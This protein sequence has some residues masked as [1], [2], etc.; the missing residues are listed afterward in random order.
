MNNFLSHK[1]IK[2]SCLTYLIFTITSYCAFSQL[3]SAGQNPPSV[4]FKQINTDQFQIIYPTLLEIEAQ[5]MANVLTHIID[6]VSN[7]LGQKPKPISI[8]LQT[9]GVVSNGFVQMAPRRSEFYTIPGQEFDAQDWLNS[10]AVHE[11]R[12]VVQFD[13]LGPNLNAPLFEELKLAIFGINLP[14]WFF[15]G[16]A[17]GIETALT[18]AGRGRQPNFELVLRTNELE[19]NKFSYSKNYFGSFKNYTPGYYP[20]GYFMTTKIRRDFGPDIL[21]QIL[22]RIKRLPIRPYN[23]S[24]SLKKYGGVT[25]PQLYKNTMQELDSLW[26]TNRE[27]IE[28]K[29]YA[30]LQEEDTKLPTSYILPYLM[31]DGNVIC[32]KGSKAQ[33]PAIIKI[34]D[35]KEEHL[36]NIGPQIEPNLHY[37][38]NKVVW[39]EYRADP[40]FSQRSFNVICI[41]D[42]ETS[43]YRQL[44]TKTRLFSPALSADGKKIIAVKV[45][46]ENIFNL[47]EIDAE[48]GDEIK[49]YP[50]PKNFTLQTPQFNQSGEQIVVTAVNADGKTLLLYRDSQMIQ[51]LP[52]ERQIISRPTFYQNQVIYKAHYNG[53]DNIYSVDLSSKKI[54]QLTQA[55]FGVYQPSVNKNGILTFSDYQVQGYNIAS[56]DL[57]AAN[58]FKP[59]DNGNA[60]VNYFEPL[61]QQENKSDVFESTPAIVYESTPYKD[62]DH[63]FYFHSLRPIIE[64]NPFLDDNDYGFDLASNNKLNTL[65]SAFGYRYNNALGR[66]GYKA[67][68]SYQKYYPQLSLNYENR[69]RLSFTRIIN[70][71]QDTSIV[72]FQWRENLTTLNIRVPYFKNWLNKNFSSSFNIETSYTNRYQATL[73]PN[74]FANKIA[75]PLTYQLFAGLNWATSQRDLAPKWGQNF[76]LSYEHLPFDTNLNGENLVFRSQ[77]Y[78][79]GFARNHSFQASYNFQTN[80]G[81]YNFGNDIPRASGFANLAPILNLSNT[82][83]LDYRFPIFYPDWEVGALAYVKRLKGGFFV[84]YENIGNGKGLRSYGAELRADLNLLRFFLPGFD[85]GSKII[86]PTKNTTKNPIF[87]FSLN[88][89]F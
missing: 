24:S 43:K 34:K 54:N 53:I 31:E 40:R 28:T 60:F 41:L 63:L 65:I 72:S 14:P 55:K 21:D 47:V 70:S 84:D 44:T 5:R 89:S 46:T 25:T 7:S 68:L 17:V 67:S 80:S 20:L 86:I 13:K 8:I 81:I 3:F 38:N 11:L 6:D 23:F 42:L 73:K 83:L 12:H 30:S 2:I 75:F 29:T 58:T 48:T 16:D 10:L 26:K 71:N 36:L 35:K 59:L 61:I 76:I 45:S 74:N 56:I 39:D 78:F 22:G 77:F 87:E 33:T 18:S 62:I 79:P 19:G 52:Q 85:L 9:Q 15:E 64:E 49:S 57:K 32:F 37:A 50:N 4:K 82:L 27:K 69:A 88:F 66:S 51:L 1:T